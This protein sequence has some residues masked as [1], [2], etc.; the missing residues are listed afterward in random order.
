[1]PSYPELKLYV[2]GEWRSRDGAPVINPADESIVGTVPHAT[3][4]DLDDALTA[5][6]EG[7][8][9]W[10]NTAPVKRAQIIQRAAQICRERRWS[11]KMAVAITLEQGEAASPI[12]QAR[13]HIR[14]TDCG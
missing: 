1:M 2:G 13:N 4:A 8:K 6:E 12:A 11:R 5:A 7:F 14:G 9:V 3:K 10:R